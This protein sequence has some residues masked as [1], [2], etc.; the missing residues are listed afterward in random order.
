[1]WREPKIGA[2]VPVVHGELSGGGVNVIGLGEESLT[3]VLTPGEDAEDL[4]GSDEP[5]R[6][7]RGC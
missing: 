5:Q 7:S 6:Q 2:I 1:L 3:A 4:A